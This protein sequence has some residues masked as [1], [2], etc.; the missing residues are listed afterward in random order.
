MMDNTGNW[1][2]QVPLAREMQVNM[3]GARFINMSLSF[4]SAIEVMVRG[5]YCV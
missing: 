1:R 5:T 3:M 2:Q 4:R